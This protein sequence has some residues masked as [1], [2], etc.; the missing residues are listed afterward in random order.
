M[1]APS[2]AGR[3]CVPGGA[4]RP[5]PPKNLGGE[6]LCG[7][8][9]EAFGVGTGSD[10]NR[11]RGGGGGRSASSGWYSRPIEKR[12]GGN[13]GV[14]GRGVAPPGGGG[15]QGAPAQ[16]HEGER[17]RG[18]EGSRGGGEWREAPEG[19]HLALPDNWARNRG[20][21]V[22]HRGPSCREPP[23]ATGNQ[24]GLRESADDSRSDPRRERGLRFGRSRPG[25]GAAS[26]IPS[27]P[28]LSAYGQRPGQAR[29]HGRLPSTIL[30]EA[31][32]ETDW[33]PPP[34]VWKRF[35]NTATVMATGAAGGD[36]GKDSP[37]G[38]EARNRPPEP[39]TSSWPP[40]NLSSGAR[41]PPPA[42]TSTPPPVSQRASGGERR[43]PGR[44][45]REKRGGGPG[46]EKPPAPARRNA[47]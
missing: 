9:P 41:L 5:Q 6:R 23:Q 47:R 38:F 24:V 10:G 42:G 8:Y 27:A 29:V 2:L 46:T 3:T 28:A 39:R 12:G 37:P 17:P 34:P 18:L 13:K 11:T 25:R 15:P 45:R 14:G 40:P 20:R 31:R 30:A 36:G 33:W 1:L 7:F 22:G 26:R 32:Y 44:V 16:A 43:S 19:G 35:A 4:S 21:E